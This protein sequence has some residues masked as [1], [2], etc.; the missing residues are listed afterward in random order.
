MGAAPSVAVNISRDTPRGRLAAFLA[1]TSIACSSGQGASTRVDAGVDAVSEG[2]EAGPSDAP[3]ADGSQADVGAEP[4]SCIGGGPGRVDCGPALESCCVSPTVSGGTFFRSY[5]GVT[6]ADRS[7]PATVSSF[8]F[9]KYE[10]TVGRFR[11][12]VAATVAGWAP[13]DGAGKHVHLNGG[14]GLSVASEGDASAGPYEPGWDTA[15]NVLLASTAADWDKNLQCFVDGQTWTTAPGPNETLPIVCTDWYEAY[16]FC[17]WDDAF[18]P[19][20]AEWNYAA[21]G[22]NQQRAYPWSQPATS[23]SVDCAHANYGACY[24][25]GGRANEVGAESPSGDGLWGQA[26]L[27]G[28]AR[29]RTLDLWAPYVVPCADCA[30]LGT[31]TIYRSGRGG[32]YSNNFSQILTSPRDED[33]PAARNPTSGIRCARTP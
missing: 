16:A 2:V 25:A 8:K 33:D 12:F 10:V 19:S 21:S 23:V 30:M 32:G 3:I 14:K 20:E 13:T 6:Y 11:R 24:D 17:I 1:L 28:N 31:S 18:L 4:P 27:A 26:D 15:W 22:G 5:D 29:E 7:Y 9:D